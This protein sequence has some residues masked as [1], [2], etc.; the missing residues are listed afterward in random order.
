MSDEEREPLPAGE[1]PNYSEPPPTV[2]PLPSRSPSSRSTNI[3][4]TYQSKP[5]FI[6]VVAAIGTLI[7]SSLQFGFNNSVINTTSGL[8]K[9]WINATYSDG[10]P[11]PE[12]DDDD[13]IDFTD[14]QDHTLL[15]FSIVVAIW[16]I[17]GLI[18]AL[19]AGFLADR[20]GRKPAML[21]NNLVAI[22]AGVL[23]GVAKPSDSAVPLIFGR[24]VS[25]LNC[26]ANTVLAP[27]FL[28]EVSWKW[29][30]DE[31]ITGFVT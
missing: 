11:G 25:G 4:S 1:Q 2:S 18:G 28:A 3:A 26:G 17:G 27:M 21:A 9:E 30:E 6:L 20:F 5:S 29:W 7:G 13:E 22:L 16:A 8:I 19:S 12:I 23:M 14:S 24:F 15:I 10:K 31:M